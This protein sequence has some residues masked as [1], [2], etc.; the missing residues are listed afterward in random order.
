[1]ESEPTKIA[2]IAGTGKSGSTLLGKLLGQV[3]GF[4]DV[5]ELINIDWQFERGQPCGCG[6]PVAACVFWQSVLEGS[7]GD[8]AN[9]DRTRWHRLKTRYLPMRLVPGAGRW[10][11]RHFT[12]LHQIHVGVAAAAQSRVTVDSS[13]SAFYG[14]V[15]GLYP[16]LDVYTIHLVRDVRGSEGSMHRLKSEG[17]GKWVSRNTWWNSIRWMIVN[18]L[19]EWSSKLTGSGYVRVRYED[20]ISNPKGTL[21][22]ILDALGESQARLHFLSGITAELAET[23]T[24]AGSN[25]RFKRGPMELKLDE[26]WKESLPESNRAVVDAL[27]RWFRRRYGY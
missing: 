22:G 15:L 16:D 14:S 8:I 6:Q 17:S 20:L 7:I 24:I 19:T 2:F 13:K 12:Q 5:G 27:T 21:Q 9:L 1:M 3:E 10:L 4:V 23:H 26:R 25:V 18:L 11:R